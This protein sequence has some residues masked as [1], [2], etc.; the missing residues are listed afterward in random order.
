MLIVMAVTYFEKKTN[1][2]I[3]IVYKTNKRIHNM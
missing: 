1:V 3:E 2:N